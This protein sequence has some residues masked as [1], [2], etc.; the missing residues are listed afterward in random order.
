[1]SRPKAS[2]LTPAE[3]AELAAFDAANASRRT[4]IL[5]SVNG[6][7]VAFDCETAGKSPCW[8]CAV[9]GPEKC[10][11]DHLPKQV[12]DACVTEARRL[13]AERDK[14][15]CHDCAFRQGS[16]ERGEEGLL[17]R[18]PRPRG[19]RGVYNGG[20]VMRRWRYRIARVWG[21]DAIDA[22]RYAV[23]RNLSM[24]VSGDVMGGFLIEVF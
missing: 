3:R 11:E 12:H 9:Y 16:P 22:V 6:R 14:G 10:L 23:H 17:V 20:G 7:P 21:L 8:A 24:R 4:R 2:G 1:M 5:A 19:L 18:R 13:Y 15:P